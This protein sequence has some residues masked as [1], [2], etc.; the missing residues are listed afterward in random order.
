MQKTQWMK[1]AAC[2]GVDSR[3][4]HPKVNQQNQYAPDVI[5]LAL[6]YCN[7]CQVKDECLTYAYDNNIQHGVYGGLTVR[8]RRKFKN[9]WRKEQNAVQDHA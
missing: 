6:S 4:F 8:G 3:I 5:A 2:S 9:K 1:Q 7:I